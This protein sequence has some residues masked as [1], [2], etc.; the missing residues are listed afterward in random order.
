MYIQQEGSYIQYQNPYISCL[1]NQLGLIELADDLQWFFF[2][3]LCFCFLTFT[4]K[5]TCTCQLLPSSI[6]YPH[7][8]DLGNT[9]SY[10]RIAKNQGG[11]SDGLKYFGAQLCTQ[12][13]LKTCLHI[14]RLHNTIIISSCL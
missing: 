8:G 14:F 12:I 11:S 5:S 1:V 3:V 13:K 2:F 6:E 10:N 4:S 7:I 9:L